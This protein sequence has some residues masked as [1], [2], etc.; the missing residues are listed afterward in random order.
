MSLLH[1]SAVEPYVFILVD[2]LAGK[3]RVTDASLNQAAILMPKEC[4]H[5]FLIQSPCGCGE[6][7]ERLDART[8]PSIEPQ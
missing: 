3:H 1:T 2:C 5:V 6:R 7:H 4:K 8:D